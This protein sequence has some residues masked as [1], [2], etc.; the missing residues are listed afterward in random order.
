MGLGEK[1][2]SRI[3]ENIENPKQGIEPYEA[4]RAPGG[5]SINLA[6]ACLGLSMNLFD[7]EFLTGASNSRRV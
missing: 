5:Q 7:N 3:T 6:I 1:P 2:I 4:V